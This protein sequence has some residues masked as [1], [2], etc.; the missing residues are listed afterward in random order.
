MKNIRAYAA[1]LLAAAIAM[2][3]AGCAVSAQ[4]GDLE[5]SAQTGDL[6]S[7]VSSGQLGGR[8]A[9]A[10][11]IGSMA[12]FSIKLF[13]DSVTG[14][15]SSLVSPLSVIFALAM[16]ANGADNETLA[17]MERLLGIPLAEFNEYLY[18]YAQRL[19]SSDKSTLNIANSIWLRDNGGR[20]RVEAD[21]L[22]RNADYYGA[23]AY[24]AA[25]DSQTL[26]DINSWVKSNTNGMIDK[27]LDEIDE[28]HLMYLINAVMFDAE[29]QSVYFKENVHKGDFTDIT[30]ASRRVDFMH[31]T[32]GIYLDDG[33]ATGFIKPYANG[34]YSFAALLPNEN[35]PIEAYIEAL[36]GEGLL[37]T[38]KNAQ[39]AVVYASMP[40]FEYE[41]TVSM[42]DALAG[43][44]IPDAFDEGKADF[45]RMA[46][47]PDGNIYIGLVLHKTFIS[48]DE[49]GTKAGA[50]TMVAMSG[51]GAPADIKTVRLDRPFV[52]AI[53]DDASGLP[54]FIGTLM[55]V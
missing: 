38:L 19:P 44:G 34:G 9:D 40:K 37:N 4:T 48:V 30:G 8:Q 25:F 54:I 17:Q 53:I 2:G 20:L 26:K 6:M 3:A 32:E 28:A 29:W 13:K 5:V 23:S 45:S 16:T 33:M 55:T 22:Q 1:I 39:D 46:V 49:L 35:V 42:N 36:T 10:A 27:I 7:G 52:Y 31:S 12:D 18:S 51:S 11:F 15:E 43:L 47:S 50:V 14:G 21:F 24:K 41:Y